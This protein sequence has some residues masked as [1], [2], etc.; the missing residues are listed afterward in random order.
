MERRFQLCV[1]AAVA[2]DKPQ[3]VALMA[4]LKTPTEEYGDDR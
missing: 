1:I 2:T 4:K 3:I